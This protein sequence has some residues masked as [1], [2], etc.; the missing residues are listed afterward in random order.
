MSKHTFDKLLSLLEGFESGMADLSLK[1]IS[2]ISA[3]L[4]EIHNQA[5]ILV[6][7]GS[8]PMGSKS[9]VTRIS[10][11][12]KETAEGLRNK[13]FNNLTEIRVAS[14]NQLGIMHAGLRQALN[15]G[16]SAENKELV[17]TQ[18]EADED[19]S[20]EI[21]RLWSDFD[22]GPTKISGVQ[23]DA[24]LIE[25]DT[26][27]FL[28]DYFTI[29]QLRSIQPFKEVDGKRVSDTESRWNHITYLEIREALDPT[30]KSKLSALKREL[31]K[32]HD[33]EY[34]QLS[35][36]YKGHQRRLPRSIKNAFT[37]IRY[38][39]VPVF[40]DIGAYKQGR[41]ETAGFEVTWIGSHFAVL[42]NQLLLCVDLDQIGI[43]EAIKSTSGKSVKN[44]DKLQAELVSIVAEI[45]H[46]ARQSGVKLVMASNT[47]ARNP[48]NPRIALVWL[49]P[50]HSRRMLF[51]VLHN[52]TKIDWDI[53]RH[54]NQ[55][56][57]LSHG[58]T[59][60]ATQKLIDASIDKHRG[61]K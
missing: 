55:A 61:G 46:T 20:A 29:P 53:P 3:K 24:N 58:K 18:F 36:S 48:N 38:P 32:R 37:A 19:K 25:S 6:N 5:T 9:W 56:P 41:L 45:N 2:E 1:R 60:A 52:S 21:N 12:T 59:P 57:K 49:I 23:I 34:A 43:K 15:G 4:L 31:V 42:E 47:V 27:R 51:D 7:S 54:N 11:W 39:V 10:R 17:R 33:D 44:S 28:N 35:E 26:K 13:Q 50:E 16:V 8:L 40:G 22:P 30:K 14:K